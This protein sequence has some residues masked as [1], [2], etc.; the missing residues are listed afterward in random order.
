LQKADIRILLTETKTTHLHQ[1][2]AL[3]PQAVLGS[4]THS[5]NLDP[6]LKKYFMRMVEDIKKDFINPLKE[7]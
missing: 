6:D 5:K 3:S 1:N 7:I 4:P 2:P